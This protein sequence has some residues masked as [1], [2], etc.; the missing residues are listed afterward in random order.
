MIHWPP[1]LVTI[2]RQVK[3]F[4]GWF[5]GHSL[6]GIPLD[7]IT[8]FVVLGLGYWV[9]TRRA[10]RR[11]A[12]AVCVCVLLTSELM[13]LVC[14]RCFPHIHTPDWGDLADVLSGLAGI[15]AA[16]SLRRLKPASRAG[17]LE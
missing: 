5:S 3:A 7:W 4:L 6:A 8:R 15:A 14:N 12:A 13:E 2:V 17:T 11:V 10:S 9:L 16:E 1:T